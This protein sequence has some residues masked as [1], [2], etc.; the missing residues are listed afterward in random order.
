LSP[1]NVTGAKI[2]NMC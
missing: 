1:T 2:P